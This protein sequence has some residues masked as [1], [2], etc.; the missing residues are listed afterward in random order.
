M[1]F[2][3]Q[4]YLLVCFSWIP[5][6]KEQIFV[7]KSHKV[8]CNRFKW[9]FVVLLAVSE[10]LVCFLLCLSCLHSVHRGCDL[11]VLHTSFLYRLLP[12]W[13]I[14]FMEK[15]SENVEVVPHAFT[16]HDWTFS[17]TEKSQWFLMTKQWES[18]DMRPVWVKVYMGY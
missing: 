13:V 17:S 6:L 1:F 3:C 8:H 2:T 11:P 16:N 12:I 7:I 9:S 14:T 18:H 4:C 5:S 15:G 10:V